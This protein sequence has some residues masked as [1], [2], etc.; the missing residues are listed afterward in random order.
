MTLLAI[1]LYGAFALW[2]LVRLAQHYR[3]SNESLVENKERKGTAALRFAGNLP[4]KLTLLH[5]L[6]NSRGVRFVIPTVG[7]VSPA[8]KSRRNYFFKKRI[9]CMA[10]RAPMVP[11]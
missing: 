4:E 10:M 9:S 3:P 8:V 5:G 7:T 1:C 11:G 6:K 2:T